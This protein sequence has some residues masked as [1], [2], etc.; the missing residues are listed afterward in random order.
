MN[1]PSASAT[2]AVGALV[3]RRP[4]RSRPGRGRSR[5]RQAPPRFA[6]VPASPLGT[7][8]GAPVGREARM[9]LGGVLCSSDDRKPQDPKQKPCRQCAS[10]DLAPHPS[11][12]AHEALLSNLRATAVRIDGRPFSIRAARR[13]RG[14][15]RGQEQS[16]K[17]P[18]PKAE[19]GT[20]LS[21][22]LAARAIRS[23]A[24]RLPNQEPMAFDTTGDSSTTRGR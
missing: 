21:R 11:P 14:A 22:P 19:T 12:D 10:H 5:A 23:M 2:R 6:C 4:R 13:S 3:D 15:T 1:R 17:R 8:R 18:P 9:L 20:R 16:T 24:C 7:I